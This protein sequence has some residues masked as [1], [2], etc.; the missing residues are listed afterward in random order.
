MTNLKY[1]A[2]P[3]HDNG[4]REKF[5]KFINEY[6]IKDINFTHGQIVMAHVIYYPKEESVNANP[7]QTSGSDNKPR[8]TNARN[9]RSKTKSNKSD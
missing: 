6:R 2:L 1:K 4:D 3:L 8:K 9:S 5:E 7:K